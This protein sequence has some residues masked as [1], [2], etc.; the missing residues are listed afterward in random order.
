MTPVWAPS[1]SIVKPTSSQL[2][3]GVVPGDTWKA[4]NW[5]YILNKITK[6]LNNLLS[7]VGISQSSGD[8]AQTSKAI[9]LIRNS[10]VYSNTWSGTILSPIAFATYLFTGAS[11]VTLPAV[12]V[13]GQ[14]IIFKSLG[15]Y[16]S[17][18]SANS[19]Q[20]I[21]TTGSTSFSV[22]SRD[23]YVSLEWDGTS[24]WYVV[25]TNGPVLKANLTAQASCNGSSAWT[26]IANGMAI[27][28]GSNLLP[29][30][31]DLEMDLCGY[32]WYST[33]LLSVA[34]GN[35]L[36]PISNIVAN[37]PTTIEVM[38]PFH[39]SIKGYILSAAA[40]IQGIYWAQSANSFIQYNTTNCGGILTARRVG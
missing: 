31:Y 13:A 36:N 15:N 34:I 35:G 19:G 2:V 39:C 40:V 14:R 6:E 25:G 11:T 4:Q 5:D 27:N 16:T 33:G 30:V 3:S 9:S 38:V 21:G 28:G 37:A 26:A 24:I 10:L 23:D 18:I 29:G 22:Y 12:P 8:D 1:G 7:A 20:T 32:A 17:T